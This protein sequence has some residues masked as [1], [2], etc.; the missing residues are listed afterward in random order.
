MT[1]NQGIKRSWLESPGTGRDV[2][3]CCYPLYVPGSK[4]PLF[5]YERQLLFGEVKSSLGATPGLS[6]TSYLA[7]KTR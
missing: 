3:V 4:V 7:C 2:L 6:K 1:S 5:P